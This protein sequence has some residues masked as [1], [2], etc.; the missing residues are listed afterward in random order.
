ML[1]CNMN[2]FTKAS[3][4]NIEINIFEKGIKYDLLY[5]LNGKNN[6]NY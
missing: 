6:G 1:L 3:K 4:R 2:Y 5:I